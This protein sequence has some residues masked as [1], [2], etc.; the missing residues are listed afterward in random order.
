MAARTVTGSAVNLDGTPLDAGSIVVTPVYPI[1]ED[2]VGI[3]VWP[4]THAI[5]A[6]AYSF[7]LLAG[8]RYEFRFLDSDGN[9]VRKVTATVPD[10]VGDITLDSI[11][12]GA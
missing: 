4:E 6:G 10:G 8:H 7:D 9:F 2:G 12:A 11:I 3:G 5:A 1:A